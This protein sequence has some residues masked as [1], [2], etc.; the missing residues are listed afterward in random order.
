[1]LNRILTIVTEGEDLA[2]QAKLIPLV[3]SKIAQGGKPTA[4]V[5]EKKVCA[6]PT[7]DPAIFAQQ[8]SQ[9]RLLNGPG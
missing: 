3:E 6:L 7:T 5:C 2:A 8:I 4:Y 9:A 1:M